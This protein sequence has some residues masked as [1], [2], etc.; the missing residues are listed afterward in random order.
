MFVTQFTCIATNKLHH[1]TYLC[2]TVVYTFPVSKTMHWTQSYVYIAL[3]EYASFNFTYRE[4]LAILISTC[5]NGHAHET[6]LPYFNL[7]YR[8][9]LAIIISSDSNGRALETVLVNFN[10][11]YR[12]C[13]DIII[14]TGSNG[15]ALETAFA[16]TRILSPEY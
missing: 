9:C 12:D 3:V 8:D 6:A 7:S 1:F 5:S 16:N 2:S 14:S 15:R 10:F 13:L 11:S 4:C